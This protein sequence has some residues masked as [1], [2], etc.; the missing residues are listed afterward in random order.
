MMT[1]TGRINFNVQQIGP[2]KKLLLSSEEVALL[3]FVVFK[4]L[5]LEEELRIGSKRGA[6]IPP[7][8]SKVSLVHYYGQ[9]ISDTFDGPS[10]T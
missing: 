10:G 4:A 3:F 6:G 8:R 9:C 5:S 7:G 2:L 1:C